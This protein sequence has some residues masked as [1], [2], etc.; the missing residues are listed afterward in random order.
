[1]YSFFSFV[2]M[3]SK[4]SELV[5]FFPDVDVLTFRLLLIIVQLHDILYIFN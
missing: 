3:L 4:I 2:L 5:L 1:M